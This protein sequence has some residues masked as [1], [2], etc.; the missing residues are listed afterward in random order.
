MTRSILWT[1]LFVLTAQFSW[2]AEKPSI[3]MIRRMANPDSKEDFYPIL[4]ADRGLAVRAISDAIRVGD[5]KTKLYALGLAESDDFFSQDY[6]ELIRNLHRDPDQKIRYGIIGLV[7]RYGDNGKQILLEMLADKSNHSNTRSVA[8][9][10]LN[11]VQI[12]EE[13]AALAREIIEKE[14]D[15]LLRLRA[16]QILI[17]HGQ[18]RELAANTARECIVSCS[19][20]LKNEAVGLLGATGNKKDLLLLKTLG[21]DPGNSERLRRFAREALRQLQW[22]LL[23]TS[24]E[25]VESLKLMLVAKGSGKSWGIAMLDQM[26]KGGDD[27]ALRLLSEIAAD[28]SHPAYDFARARGYGQK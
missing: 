2:G 26:A 25:K 8:L 19:G 28:S 21:D 7:S 15:A 17:R 3:D 9:D 6:Y 10:F 16:A 11:K 5:Q 12:P 18:G 1:A 4:K 20:S 13:N 23:P 14:R 22:E 24:Q 27:N